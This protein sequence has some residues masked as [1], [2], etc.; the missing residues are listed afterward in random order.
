MSW[1]WLQERA[2]VQRT[3][4][5]HLR[6]GPGGRSTVDGAPLLTSSVTGSHASSTG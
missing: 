3:L 5:A 6:S 1:T 2:R 4:L